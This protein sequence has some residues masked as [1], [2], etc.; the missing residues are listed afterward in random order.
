MLPRSYM[1]VLCDCLFD[2]VR[3][4]I[5]H[6]Q[7]LD[8]LCELSTALQALMALDPQPDEVADPTSP[9]SRP[10]SPGPLP[11]TGLS[12][13]SPSANHPAR[14]QFEPMLRPILLD[15]QTRLVFR[16][17]AIVQSEVLRYSP[18]DDDLAPMRTPTSKPTDGSGS[19]RPSLFAD[20]DAALRARLPPEEVQ[21]QWYPTVR[22]TVWVLSRIHSFVNVSERGLC[23]PPRAD[24]VSSRRS[25]RTLPPRPSPTAGSHWPQP[26]S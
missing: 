9:L 12:M 5:L 1:E 18:T 3:P 23:A 19:S 15:V 26:P 13:A 17:E 20:T 10:S 11:W 14:F 22:T 24:A 4:R 7:N 6:E 16:S 8:V 2:V 25:S 21:R